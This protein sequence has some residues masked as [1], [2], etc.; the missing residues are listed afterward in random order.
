M[1]LFSR[2]NKGIPPNATF[3]L[4]QQ[5]TAKLQEFNG[6]PKS[7][8]LMALDTHGTSDIDELSNTT[9]LSKGKLEKMIPQLSRSGYIQFMSRGMVAEDEL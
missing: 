3:M 2:G 1:S 6:D 9:R 5:G 7:Q 8:V 4:T